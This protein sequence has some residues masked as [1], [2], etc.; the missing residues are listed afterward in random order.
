MRRDIDQTESVAQPSII[1]GSRVSGTH[2]ELR[3]LQSTFQK[4]SRRANAHAL[5]SD[6]FGST[7]APTLSGRS[8]VLLLGD[9]YREIAKYTSDLGTID[10]H[11]EIQPIRYCL[12]RAAEAQDS[13]SDRSDLLPVA[14]REELN[15]GLYAPL[16]RMRYLAYRSRMPGSTSG[17]SPGAEDIRAAE[18]FWEQGGQEGVGRS[19]ARL[20]VQ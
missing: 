15:S 17:E 11:G 13:V 20:S 8:E 7:I 2:L 9:L 10:L 16:V 5:A 6:T 4:V 18:R 12:Q 19:G 1:T 14:H 3:T